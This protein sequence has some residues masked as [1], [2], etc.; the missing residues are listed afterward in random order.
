MKRTRLLLVTALILAT[1]Q[2]CTLLGLD[3]N[4]GALR[5]ATREIDGPGTLMLVSKWRD[6]PA[7][8]LGVPCSHTTEH[9]RGGSFEAHYI[10]CA[11]E[12]WEKGE[13]GIGVFVGYLPIPFWSEQE[14]DV[15]KERGRL[16]G[17]KVS[18]Y[19]WE[20]YR[21]SSGTVVSEWTQETI[22]EKFLRAA[23]FDTSEASERLWLHVW[24]YARTPEQVAELKAGLENLAL[25]Q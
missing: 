23:R 19:G 17:L 18:W 15:T 13:A 10:A 7:L 14:E 5:G 9:Q 6:V 3:S 1:P 24:V 22:I 25:S 11:G 4:E 8:A 2:L 20:E 16:L 21:E 12:G